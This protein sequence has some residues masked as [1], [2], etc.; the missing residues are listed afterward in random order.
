VA[1]QEGL[2]SRDAVAMDSSGRSRDPLSIYE[3]LGV[4]TAL[5]RRVNT[6]LGR[7]SQNP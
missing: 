7:G 3:Q 2:R 1:G 4:R 5:A 6:L